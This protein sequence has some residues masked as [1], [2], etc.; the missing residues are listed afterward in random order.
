MAAC[1]TSSPPPDDTTAPAPTRAPAVEPDAGAAAPAAPD[2]TVAAPAPARAWWRDVVGYE[3]FVRSFQDS[4]GDGIGDLQ[5]VTDRLDYLKDLG[6]GLVWLMPINPSPSYHGYDVVDYRDVNPEYG[7]LA[8]LDALVAAGKQRG[9]KIIIDLL[10]NHS[11]DKNPWFIE[12]KSGPASPK[13]DWYI[14][15]KDAPEGWAR[16]WDGAPLWHKLPGP[17]GGADEYYYALFWSG[18]PDLNLANPAVEREMQDIMRFWLA[19]GLAGFRVDAIRYLIEGEHGETA[20]TPMTHDFIKRM[21]KAVDKD[22][23]EALLLG[24]AWTSAEDQAGYYGDGDELDMTFS[25]DM[26]AAMVEC[27]KDGVRSRLNQIVDRSQELFAKDRGFEAPFLTNHDMP[28]VMRQLWGDAARM[29]VAAA[30]MLAA[31]GT[32]FI[33]YGEEIGMVGGEARDDENKRTPMHWNADKNGGFT[34]GTP[35]WPMTDEKAGVDVATQSADAGS[36]LNLYKRLVKTRLGSEALRH[37][38]Q[39]RLDLHAGKGVI[40]F[41]RTAGAARVL[42]LLNF[43]GAAVEGFSVPVA[44]KPR[45]LAA[46][47]LVGAPTSDGQAVAVGGLGP[48]S[49]AWIALE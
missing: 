30:A 44:G 42:V 25:F 20:D 9:I 38:D 13:R 16:P 2:A 19:R 31:P 49:F 3:I 5:G 4:N 23:P 28:R 40:G 7:T 17:P 41:V 29:R 48:Q 6:V 36:L 32:P 12:S 22:Y 46:E 1:R 39:A 21:R 11:S 10:L 18:M 45:V 34:T 15:R 47:G 33:Y 43:D 35:W 27:A 8:N 24:E 14:W 26:A 37:G